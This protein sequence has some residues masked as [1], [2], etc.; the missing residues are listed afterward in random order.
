M[1]RVRSAPVGR[2][3]PIRNGREAK[4]SDASY[5]EKCEPTTATNYCYIMLTSDFPLDTQLAT[6]VGSSIEAKVQCAQR[7]DL[8]PMD[9]AWR[10][11]I[12]DRPE[13]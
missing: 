13:I 5:R 6:F 7:P 11:R 2:R 3:E 12:L 9:N 1:D 10:T 8:D 4:I